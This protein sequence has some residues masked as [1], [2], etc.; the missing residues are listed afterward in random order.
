MYIIYTKSYEWIHY[1]K[2]LRMHTIDEKR[3]AWI[4]FRKNAT[5]GYN[6]EKKL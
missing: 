5:K 6:I 1:I 2:K 4:H 3:Y